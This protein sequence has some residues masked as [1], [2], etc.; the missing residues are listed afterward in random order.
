MTLSDLLWKWNLLVNVDG[1]RPLTFALDEL[2]RNLFHLKSFTNLYRTHRYEGFKLR[3]GHDGDRF[4]DG[5]FDNEPF[6][7]LFRVWRMNLANRSQREA[8]QFGT[9]QQ[10]PSIDG[11][12]TLNYPNFVVGVGQIDIDTVL[13]FAASN[14]GKLVEVLFHG[15]LNRARDV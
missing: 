1:R 14:E 3:S 13:G 2:G 10:F 5:I 15:I 4:I 12:G 9:V 7:L 8:L 11:R 6:Q